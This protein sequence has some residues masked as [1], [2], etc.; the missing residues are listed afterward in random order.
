M[1]FQCPYTYYI[2]RYTARIL[3]QIIHFPGKNRDNL[4]APEG[5]TL[6]T[7]TAK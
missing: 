3:P 2:F 6:N 1:H 5:K 7:L 4:Q